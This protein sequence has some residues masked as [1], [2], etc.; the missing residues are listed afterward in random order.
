MPTANRCCLLLPL[1]LPLLLLAQRPQTAEIRSL[2]GQPT[3]FLNQQPELPFMYALTHVT[4]GRWSWEELPAHNLRQM[5]EAGV[6]LFQIDLWLEDIWKEKE[7]SLD[8]ALVKRQI[9]GVLDACPGAAVMVRLHV[10]APLWWNRSH[11]EECVQ[12]AD[13]PLQDLPS[14]LP[15]NHE[16]GDILRANRASLASELWRE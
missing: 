7:P 5:G 9:R 8:M 13:G 1:L 3:L 2:N 10:N 15:F 11:L 14:G 6:R 12:Y 16:D 4:G